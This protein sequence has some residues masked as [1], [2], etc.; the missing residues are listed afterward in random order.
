[1]LA[2]ASLVAQAPQPT[3]RAAADL[4]NVSAGT[5]ECAFSR[6]LRETA[7]YYILGV[8]P[9]ARDRDGKLHYIEVS[10]PGHKS[11]V[12]HRTTITIPKR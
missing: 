7:A 2:V 3:F 5:S 4:I 12:R 10:V 6:V 8:E 11:T 9:E 1:M